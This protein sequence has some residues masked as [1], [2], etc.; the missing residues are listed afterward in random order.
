M[1]EADAYASGIIDGE[2][3][4]GVKQG[5]CAGRASAAQI[6]VGMTHVDTIRWLRDHFQVG[7]ISVHRPTKYKP[8]FRWMVRGHAAAAIAAR[9]LRWS[10]TK[11]KELEALIEY[12]EGARTRP[13]RHLDWRK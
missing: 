11:R 10:I 2:G 12:V 1:S 9:L 8:S 3:H 13:G 7:S 6:Q 5:R 4:V